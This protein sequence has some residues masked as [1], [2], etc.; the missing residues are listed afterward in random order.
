[1]LSKILLHRG[2]RSGLSGSPAEIFRLAAP[3]HS[4]QLWG[5]SRKGASSGTRRPVRSSFPNRVG[6]RAPA[7][8]R[9]TNAQSFGRPFQPPSTIDDHPHRMCE[10]TTCRANQQNPVQPPRKKYFAFAVGQISS[11]SLRR[12]TRQRG[13]SRVV[14]NARWD[15]VDAAASARKVIAGRVSR[16]RAAGAQDERRWLRTAKP[17]GPDTRCWCQAVGGEFDPTGSISPSSR[18]RR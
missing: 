6:K 5:E 16:E 13:G 17:C 11:T 15:A 7:P 1:M 9:P 8:H 14:T 18:Q 10:K 12:L 4:L 2:R 3:D